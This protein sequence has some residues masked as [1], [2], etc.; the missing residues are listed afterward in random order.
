MPPT[1]RAYQQQLVQWLDDHPRGIVGDVAGLGKSYPTIV[2][3]QQHPGPNLIV[4]PGYLLP[5]WIAYLREHDVDPDDIG[6]VEGPP[7]KRRQAL[8]DPARYTLCTYATLAQS[9]P[10]SQMSQTYPQL[11]QRHWSTVVFDEAHRLRSRQTLGFRQARALLAERKWL[12]TG[13]PCY[14]NAGDMWT[15]LHITDPRKFSSFWRWVDT[16]CNTYDNGWARVVRDPIDPNDF[17]AMWTPYMIRRSYE[18]VA[19]DLP[20]VE[21]PNLVRCQMTT[22]TQSNQE[23][24]WREYERFSAR[25][26]E[27]D[28]VQAQ[29]LLTRMR[30]VSGTDK[31]KLSTLVELVNDINDRVV[32]FCWF[33]QTAD[34]LASAL[35]TTALVHGGLNPAE[36]LD[37]LAQF[38][39]LDRG[40]LVATI[41]S[42]SEG[43]NLQHTHYVVFY[44]WDWVASTNQQALARFH[45]PGQQHAVQPYYIV[46]ECRPLQTDETPLSIDERILAANARNNSTTYI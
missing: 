45:R 46:A 23:T 24:L 42:I 25:A 11:A 39:S 17:Q 16:Y 38:A 6:Q 2:A 33:R 13:S 4:A 29:A 41:P 5:N 27:G 3:M 26:L 32:V 31:H 34:A 43:L 9:S 1:L 44:E 28:D 20:P 36:R 37:R 30:T 12:L 10:R 19:L 7:N 35:E 18:D 22:F 14:A 8:D 21:A 15:L 40:R